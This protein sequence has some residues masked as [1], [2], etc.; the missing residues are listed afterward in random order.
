MKWLY[1]GLGTA[2]AV[3]MIAGGISVF[4]RRVSE[5]D[6]EDID[7]GVVKRYWS[8]APKVITSNEI[9]E[10]HCELSLIA[11][12][13]AEEIGHR[14]YKLDA[15]SK[16]NEVIV[17]YDWRD[18][19][20]ESDHAQY[21]AN[22]DFMVRLQEIAAAYDFAQ[23][24]GYYHSVSGLPDMYGETLDVVYA[25]G[26]RIHVHDNQS[27]FLPYE[28]EKELVMLFGA[29]TKIENESTKEGTISCQSL[30]N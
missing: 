5:P 29:A 6:H 9:C 20:G 30:I 16:D 10:F 27:R 24:N 28:A 8:D 12:F 19:Y 21:R 26:E 1:I 14:V 7:G 4:R 17:M 2:L 22:A 11:A 3:T 25:S 15:V 23:Y 13:E 18:R